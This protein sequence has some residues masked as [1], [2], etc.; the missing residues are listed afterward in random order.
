M[1][2]LTPE[3]LQQ[4]RDK[5][6]LIELISSYIPMK[7]MGVY[8]KACCPFHQEKTPSF[9]VQP[10]SSHYHCFGCQAHGDAI[11]FLMQYQQLSFQEAVEC[12]AEK[13]QVPLEYSHQKE[14][15]VDKKHL[16]EVLQIAHS[17]YHKTL[18]DPQSG[19]L[20]QKYL[21]DRGISKEFIEKYEIGL[22]PK[23]DESFFALMKEKKVSLKDLAEVGLITDQKR[24]FFFDR[25]MFPIRDARGSVIAFSARLFKP[26]SK[27]GKYINSK[28]TYLFKKSNVL[29]GLNYSR[30]RLAKNKK[31]L[32]VEGQVDALRLI[33]LGLNATVAPLGTALTEQHVDK[34]L[35]LGVENA[36]LAFD[37]DA[38]GINAAVKSGNLLQKKGISV[39]V[40]SL[41][42]DLDPDAFIRE[43]SLEAFRKLIQAAPDYL[44]FLM[45]ISS[46]R[47]DLSIPANK[48]RVLEKITKEIKTWEHPVMVFE[49]LKKLSLLAGVPLETVGAEAPVAASLQPKRAYLKHGAPL[50]LN[51]LVESDLLTWLLQSHNESST[52]I[53]VALTHLTLDSFYNPICRSLFSNVLECSKGAEKLDRLELL[54]KISDENTAQ[55]LSSLFER[56]VHLDHA[57]PL[58]TKSLQTILD[59]N[60]MKK[61]EEIKIKIQSGLLSDDEALALAKEFDEIQKNRPQ[62]HWP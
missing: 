61:R 7:K 59:R 4:L 28:E 26:E 10:G 16:L 8:Y 5:V 18:L 30:M 37:S 62:V 15:G 48:S 38:A 32:I 17:F 42:N 43:N 58:F 47:T 56:K 14:S 39:F 6:D 1:G 9:V 13:F 25:I 55:L 31:A 40:V 27:G 49:S 57:K 46:Q 19:A 60:W 2:L 23:S 45:H 20:A 53:E 29:F 24:P 52:F 50:D 54:S 44:S 41:P 12:L 22:S 33:S 3:C 35:Q 36:Y 51:Q 11:A 21:E 34:L